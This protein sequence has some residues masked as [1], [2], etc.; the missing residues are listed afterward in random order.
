MEMKVSNHPLL[1]KF[2][3]PYRKNRFEKELMFFAF[4]TY[5]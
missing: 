1:K 2:I 5:I 3:K 4:S